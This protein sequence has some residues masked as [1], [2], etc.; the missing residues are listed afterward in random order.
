MVM[1]WVMAILSACSSTTLIHSVPPGAKVF[2]DDNYIGNAPI[3]YRDNKVSL[4][5]TRF[6]LEKEGYDA[7]EI[8]VMKDEAL[9]GGAILGGIFF[10][11]PWF[12]VLKYNPERTYE[13]KKSGVDV[14]PRFVQEDSKPAGAGEHQNISSANSSIDVNIPDLGVQH[15]MRFALIIGNEDYSSFQIDLTAEAN[16]D[17]ARNDAEV[18]R[19]YAR[20]TLGVPEQNIIYLLDGTTGQ[21]RQAIQKMNLILKNTQGKAEAYMYFAG[22]GMPD[23]ITRDAY[24]MPVDVSGKQPADGISLRHIYQKFS[25]FPAQHVS[26]FID[27]CFSGGARNQGL[28][29]ARTVKVVPKQEAVPGNLI[30][31][32]ATSGEQSALPY[33]AQKHG[34]FTYHLLKKLQ[35]TKGNI[36]Y[37]EMY[38]YL[39]AEVALQSV[40]LNNKEQNPQMM[41]GSERIHDWEQIRFLK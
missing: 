33:D 3:P 5:N 36:S 9:H 19:N 31:F 25:E 41:P 35:E 18:F 17:Y 29:A 12:W 11:L 8:Q 30:V 40:L 24:L 16:V 23:E 28:L 34:M 26:I 38:E 1:I 32:A 15:A 37:K 6:R 39:S 10:L 14:P 27:A 7:F 2:V 21:M 22:H 4:S 13:L 20:K